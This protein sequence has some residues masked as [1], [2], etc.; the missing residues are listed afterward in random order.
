MLLKIIIV[1]IPTPQ[2][3]MNIKEMLLKTKIIGISK[4]MK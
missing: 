1:K 3:G 2:E 4:K